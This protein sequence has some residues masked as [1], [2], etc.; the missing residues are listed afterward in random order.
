MIQSLLLRYPLPFDIIR[1]HLSFS[2]PSA[3]AVG[4]EH[5]YEIVGSNA[6][7]YVP[8]CVTLPKSLLDAI[9]IIR[10]DVSK[11]TYIRRMFER[12]LWSKG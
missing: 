11:G 3:I 12:G 8:V 10:G 7:P 4:T 6:Y 5:I 2:I 1:F 9:D